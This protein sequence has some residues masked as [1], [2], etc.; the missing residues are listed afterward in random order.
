VLKE[1][2]N[3]YDPNISQSTEELEAMS[4]NAFRVKLGVDPFKRSHMTWL[5]IFIW[6]GGGD[7]YLIKYDLKV[8][9]SKVREQLSPSP[10]TT[11]NTS[12]DLLK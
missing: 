11:N 4:N 12:L 10:G 9:D 8:V 3:G 7:D 2:V 5:I 6:R 1:S